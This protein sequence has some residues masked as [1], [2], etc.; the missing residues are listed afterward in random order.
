MGGSRIIRFFFS[1][2][3]H[4]IEKKLSLQQL[5]TIDVFVFIWFMISIIFF[6]NPWYVGIS[7]IIIFWYFRSREYIITSYLIDQIKNKDYKATLLS[8]KAQFVTLLEVFLTLVLWY[9]TDI[10]YSIGFWF[11]AGVLL[12][13]LPISLL[14]IMYYWK[15]IKS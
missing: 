11:L 5:L 1:R 2:I 12:V 13:G 15:K 6:P 8:I 3:M 9:L 4:I 10:S 7:Y 14:W